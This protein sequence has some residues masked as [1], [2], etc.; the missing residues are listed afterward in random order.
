MK[1]FK[2]ERPDSK[3]CYFTSV[4]KAAKYIGVHEP[5]VW[6]ALKH[7][8]KTKGYSVSETDGSNIVCRDVNPEKETID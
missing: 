6:Y 2:I 5:A 7:Q 3:E 4:Y 8:T 1:L